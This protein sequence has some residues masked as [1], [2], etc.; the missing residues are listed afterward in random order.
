MP[1]VFIASVAF[2]D[3]LFFVIF[4]CTLILHNDRGWLP[5]LKSKHWQFKHGSSSLLFCDHLPHVAA[6]YSTDLLKSSNES[7]CF[8]SPYVSH[9]VTVSYSIN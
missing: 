2:V 9:Y 4:S 7:E 1:V 6:C 5:W 3:C 8:P